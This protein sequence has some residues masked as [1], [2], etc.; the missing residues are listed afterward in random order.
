MT[1]TR[2]PRLPTLRIPSAN[3]ARVRVAIVYFRTANGIPHPSNHRIERTQ[4]SSFQRV[5][6]VGLAREARGRANVRCRD[7]AQRVQKRALRRLRRGPLWGT[8][9][10]KFA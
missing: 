9:D 10:V 8:P 6:A 4:R 1:V 2:M 5:S 3:R 7:F